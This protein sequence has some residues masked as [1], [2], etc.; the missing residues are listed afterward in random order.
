MIEKTLRL[1]AILLAGIS[2]TAAS[3]FLQVDIPTL[4]RMSESVIHAKVVGRQD[5]ADWCVTAQ[6]RSGSIGR[7]LS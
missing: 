1:A 3:T 7:S 4:K 5:T 2:L 6:T